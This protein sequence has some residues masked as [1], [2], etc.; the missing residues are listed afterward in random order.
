V[1][2]GSFV[3]GGA[4]DFSLNHTLHIRN[5]FRSFVYEKNDQFHVWMVFTYGIGQMLQKNGF[6]RPWWGNYESSLSFPYGNKKVHYSPGEFLRL[7]FKGKLLFGIER[8]EAVESS[9]CGRFIRAKTVNG[10]QPDQSGILFP[11]PGF[12]RVT[13]D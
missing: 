10:F 6:P 1:S 9:S 8:G 7:G 5:L 2:F 4:Y 13:A 11:V 12:S 3:E